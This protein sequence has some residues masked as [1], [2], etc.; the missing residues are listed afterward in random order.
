MVGS[1]GWGSAR[2]T[3]ISIER[4]FDVCH[5]AINSRV[6]SLDLAFPEIG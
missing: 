6:G 4:G 3:L 5:F 1:N 2:L